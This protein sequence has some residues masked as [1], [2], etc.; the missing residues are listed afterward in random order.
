MYGSMPLKKDLL[1]S[2]DNGPDIVLIQFLF[3]ASLLR[4]EDLLNYN[5]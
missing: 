4:T 2:L 3:L 5:S 1:I